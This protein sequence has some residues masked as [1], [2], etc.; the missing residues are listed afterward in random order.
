MS[1]PERAQQYV[2]PNFSSGNAAARGGRHAGPKGPA[3]V[4]QDPARLWRG[5]AVVFLLC[6][7]LIGCRQDM[8]DQPKYEPLERSDFF[9]DGR[10]SRPLVDGTVARGQLN[11]DD[12]MY[13]GKV[14][15]VPVTTFPMPITP[16]V[17]ERGRQRFD[18]YCAPCHDRLGSG[19]GM[20][21]QRGFRR[22]QTFHSERLRQAPPGYFFDVMTNG[23]G[24]MADYRAQV[25]VEDRWAIAAYIRALQLSQH[26]SMTDVPAEA[27]RELDAAAPSPPQQPSGAAPQPRPE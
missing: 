16:A 9:A 7:A 3:Y 25:R 2:G 10:A 14:G 1:S 6:L 17:L 27:R 4:R 26:A 11:A 12:A 18:I 24:A 20:V 15:E 19:G 22:P 21:V 5:P 8:H 13:R 23:F